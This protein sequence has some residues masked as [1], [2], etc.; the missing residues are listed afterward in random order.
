MS[1]KVAKWFKNISIAKKLYFVL[2]IMALLIALELF[3]LW[4]SL[5]ALSSVRAFV[6]G[7]GLWSKAQKD[8]VYYLQKYSRTYSENDYKKFEE[9]MKVPQGDH[10]ALVELVKE[11]PDLAKAK[12]GFIEGRNNENDVDGMIN[13][14]RRFH[15][16]YYI[17]KAIGIWTEADS[18]IATLIPIAQKLHAEI[19]LKNPSDE[20]VDAIISEIDPIN[21]RLTSLEDEFSFTLGE[22]SRWLENLVLK[23]LFLIALTV[24]LTGLILT[25]SVSVGIAKGIKE[26]TTAANKVAK[27]EFNVK[28][29]VFSKDEI[30]QLATVFNKM[31]DDLQE[32]IGQKIKA[33]NELKEKTQDLIRSNTELE[34]FAYVASHDLQEPLR[35]ITSYL[36]LIEERYKDKLDDDANEFIAFAVDGAKRMKNLIHSLLEYSRVHRV[37]KFDRIETN[38]LLDRVQQNLNSKIMENKVAIKIDKLPSINGDSVLI[39]QLFQNLI[40]NAIKF[41]GER[42]PEIKISGKKNEGEFLFSVADNGIGISEEYWDKI[43]I[44]LQRLHSSEKYPGTGIGLA[45]CKKIVE[46]HGGRVWLESKPEEGSTFYF[47]IKEMDE[48]G[49]N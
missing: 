39:S 4:F 17:S 19:G 47:T 3:T 24:E 20:K 6:A 21:E 7:E 10:K 12:A 28:A 9:F 43:F 18:T 45:I 32:N 34:Q 30:G 26:I 33:E 46:H 35:M 27:A 2:G 37:Q 11:E 44:I 40:E 5:N 14:F 41:K 15:D 48:Q 1:I 25:I 16:V 29:Q 38:V 31:I 49:V 36:Q 13:L 8:A 22:G 23:I 42:D